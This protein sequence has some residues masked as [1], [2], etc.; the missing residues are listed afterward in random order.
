MMCYRDMTFCPA[1]HC[2]KFETCHRALTDKVK[3]AAKAWW[4][5]DDAPIAVFSE[6]EKLDCF[7]QE[8]EIDT[9]S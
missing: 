3:A 1:T 5:G 9:G 7:E 6:P 4:K 2:A 8:T